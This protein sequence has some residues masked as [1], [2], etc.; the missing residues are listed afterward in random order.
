MRKRMRRSLLLHQQRTARRRKMNR[1]NSRR[2]VRQKWL[3]MFCFY[4]LS[5]FLSALNNEFEPV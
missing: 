4:Y 5:L 2:R 1:V 3:K